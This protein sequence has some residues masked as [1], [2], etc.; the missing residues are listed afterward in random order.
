MGITY[1]NSSGL[2]PEKKRLLE[3]IAASY[4]DLQRERD[5]AMAVVNSLTDK[6]HAHRAMLDAY[7]IPIPTAANVS[8]DDSIHAS[9]IN[10]GIIRRRI[11]VSST[12]HP[13]IVSGRTQRGKIQSYIDE[14]LASGPLNVSEI[15]EKVALTAGVKFG[16]SSIYR[17][18]SDGKTNKHY[19]SENGK[20]RL[21]K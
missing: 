5:E 15:R 2:S 12:S 4:P 14:A 3:E 16:A 8:P 7:N 18:L 11:V 17:I 1:T 6:L 19:R 10:S 9:N 13:D 21:A 20:W